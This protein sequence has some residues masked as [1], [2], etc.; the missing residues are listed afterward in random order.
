MTV[1]VESKSATS[2]GNFFGV[3]L[4][5]GD[6]ELITL[7]ALRVISVAPVIAIPSA[8]SDGTSIAEG[9][10]RQALASSEAAGGVKDGEGPFGD[11]E[12]LEL[13]LPMTKDRA[14]LVNARE[15]AARSIAQKLAEGK[16]VAFITLGDPMFFSTFSYLIPYVK[17]LSP[18]S[19]VTAIPGVTAPSA[20]SAS[21][22]TALAE[23]NETVA[24]VPASYNID[25][26]GAILNSF[27]SIVLMKVGSVIDKVLDLLDETGLTGKALFI[28]KASW[29]D[30]ER[31]LDLSE[32]KGTKPGYFSMIIVQKR[33]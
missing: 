9:I 10:L 5:P 18:G 23:G 21:F 31:V 2:A 20:A 1:S 15:G 25:A 22:G 16:D 19:G 24:I 29:D 30:E 12:I 33:G 4:G 13:V 3:G 27:D 32:L 7:K 28:S 14:R 11:K 26:L 6:P 8:N 17:D